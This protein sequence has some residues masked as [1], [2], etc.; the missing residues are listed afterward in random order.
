MVNWV[1]IP[2]RDAYLFTFD[3]PTTRGARHTTF[4]IT[5]GELIALREC[6]RGEQ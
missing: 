4:E 3:T 1:R 2:G 6:L 5:G